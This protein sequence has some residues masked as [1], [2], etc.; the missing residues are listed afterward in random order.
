MMKNDE[1]FFQYPERNAANF[2]DIFRRAEQVKT[3]EKK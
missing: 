3:G 1:T 2:G